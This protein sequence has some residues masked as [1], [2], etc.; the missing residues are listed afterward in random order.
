MPSSHHTKPTDEPSKIG[1]AEIYTR[2]ATDVYRFALHLSGNRADAED[3]TSEAFARALASPQAIRTETVRAYLFTIARHYHLESLRKSA[4]QVALDDSLEDTNLKPNE[5]A[6][7][8]SELAAVN[9]VLRR[10]SVT[11]RAVVSVALANASMGDAARADQWYALAQAAD[12]LNTRL[13]VNRALT[14][15]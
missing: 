15:P 3:I 10:I 7:Q 1:F 13:Y 9:A 14:R 6:E 12:S 8:A 11:D 5:R 4:R 2:H